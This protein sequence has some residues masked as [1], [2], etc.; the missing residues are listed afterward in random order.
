MSPKLDVTE[1]PSFM[2][3][4]QPQTHAA[5][6]LRPTSPIASDPRRYPQAT[7]AAHLSILFAMIEFYL[8]I[9]FMY[10]H[11]GL[12]A[13]VVVVDFGYGSGGG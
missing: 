11:M 1:A 13:V 4:D 5:I 8:F 10:F 9:Y 12:V 7:I 3:V 6:H 2:A